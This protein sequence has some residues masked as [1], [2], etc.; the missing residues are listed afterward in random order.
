[1]G[2]KRTPKLTEILSKKGANYAI[3]HNHPHSSTFSESD[4]KTL[5]SSKSVRK[6]LAIG[7]DG[8][9]YTINNKNIGI[10]VVNDYRRYYNRFKQLNYSDF[11]CMDKALEAIS[12]E[13][14]LGYGRR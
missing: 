6:M 4:L 10:D 14:D 9:V 8:T 7:H 1:M 5:F 13:F 3:I 12:K 2:V 11:T